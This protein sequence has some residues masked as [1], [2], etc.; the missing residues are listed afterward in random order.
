MEDIVGVELVG[1]GPVGGN[2]AIAAPRLKLLGRR[3]RQGI[4]GTGKSL[5]QRA[6]PAAQPVPSL[7]SG[8][9]AAFRGGV[10]AIPGRSDAQ[11]QSGERE[12]RVVIQ[13]APEVGGR[14]EGLAPAE[15]GVAIE[16][17]P[18]GGEGR[19]GELPQP[20][21]AFT[22][23]A[24][25]QARG[26]LVHQ[27]CKA[28]RRTFHADPIELAATGNLEQ[29]DGENQPVGSSHH[30]SEKKAAGLHPL[31]QLQG[32]LRSE[33]SGRPS[34]CPA[35]FGQHD[36]GFGGPEAAFSGQL[37]GEEIEHAVPEIVE[38]GVC[39]GD[40]E[41]GD[42]NQ[43]RIGRRRVGMQGSPG[44]IA[45]QEQGQPEDRTGQDLPFPGNCPAGHRSHQRPVT[46]GNLQPVEAVQQR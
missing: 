24:R 42:G 10:V 15:L 28:V 5:Q 22:G 12:S 2:L 14:L 17:G 37:G 1:V 30:V 36:P 18:E 11:P 46:P 13:G 3:C 27:L 7:V 4:P 35:E 16:V 20:F 29:G 38:R 23:D 32:R 21:L 25:K 40:P 9:E 31:G 19:A 33:V 43:A 34:A 45:D 39:R 41:R 44:A 26:D 8:P 6:I